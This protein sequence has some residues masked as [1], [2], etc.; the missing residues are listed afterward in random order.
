MEKVGE[1]RGRKSLAE[2]NE[3]EDAALEYPFRWYSSSSEVSVLIES[4]SLPSFYS[5]VKN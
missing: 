4:W 2:D 1:G 3:T 5:K